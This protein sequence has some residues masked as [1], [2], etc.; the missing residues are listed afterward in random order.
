MKIGNRQLIMAGL[1][2]ALGAAVYLNWQ[3]SDNSNLITPTS[4]VQSSKELGKAEYVN[5]TTDSTVPTDESCES[6][7]SQT[8][9]GTKVNADEYFAQAKT[10]RQTAQDKISDLAKE[11]LESADS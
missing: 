5:N 1:V 8:A 3:F 4:T 11:V 2:L 10:D 9:A 7:G 6:A